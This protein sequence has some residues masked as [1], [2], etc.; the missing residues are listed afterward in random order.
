MTRR[1]DLATRASR[2]LDEVLG[3][4]PSTIV[5]DA[6]IQRFQY[7][8]D[9]TWKAAQRYLRDCEGLDAGS[10]AEAMRRCGALGI[11]DEHWTRQALEMLQ[12]RNLAAHTYKEEVA[13]QVAAN[14][15]RH[16][17]VL[18]AWHL[19]IQDRLRGLQSQQ[20]PK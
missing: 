10:P 15:P 7:T 14:L 12:D 11:L 17:A 5:R 6:S 2:T 20:L 3:E 13:V 19:A 4:P 1:L 16:A 18:R 9:A 8:F